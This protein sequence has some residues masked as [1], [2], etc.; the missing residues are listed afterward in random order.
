MYNKNMIISKR[1]HYGTAMLGCVLFFGSIIAAI[2]FSYPHFYTWFAVGSW[3]ILDWIDYHK[4]RK[5]ILGYFYNHKH[6]ITFFSF[7]FLATLAAFLI[8]YIYGVRLSNMWEW[9]AYSSLDFV[10]MYTIMNVAYIF[11][12]YELFRVIRTY[13]KPYISEHHRVSFTI[14]TKS[15]S[16]L[17]ISGIIVGII[18]LLIPLL[19]WYVGSISIMKY[20]MFLPFV[21]MWLVSD[22]ITS[23]LKG[24]SIISEVIRGN[25]LQILSLTLAGSIATLVTEII[26]LYAHEWVYRFMPF[27]NLQFFEI[28]I[29]VIIGWVPLVIGV[30]SLLNMVKHVSYLKIK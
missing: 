3:L 25:M 17:N 21:G 19:S 9:P 13:L 28:P 5:S 4:N 8:D 29:A 6:R 22:N 1:L 24:K 2:F 15:R 11:G 10:R 18:F 23:L 16:I 7:F 26:N 27:E 20:L 30:I 14:K 12:M